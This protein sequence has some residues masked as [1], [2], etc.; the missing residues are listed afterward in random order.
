MEGSQEKICPKCGTP[1]LGEDNF[2]IGC[3]TYVD[4]D[5]GEEKAKQDGYYGTAGH[6]EGAGYQEAGDGV[7]NFDGSGQQ[8][9]MGNGYVLGPS[10]KP[11]MSKSILAFVLIGF[12]VFVGI[13]AVD[14]M[15][16]V[17]DQVTILYLHEAEART[18]GKLIITSAGDRIKKMEDLE[19]VDVSG[20]DAAVVD[21]AMEQIK[22]SYATYD[23]YDFITY[24]VKKEN[25]KVKVALIYQDLDKSKNQRAMVSMG[26][27]EG[28]SYVSLK[29]MVKSLKKAGWTDSVY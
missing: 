27:L 3:G 12:L 7:G 11:P 14:L 25:G 2:C 23:K 10:G 18:E 9:T 8:G 21:S 20:L 17:R 15:T 13:F 16:K 29:E 5:G 1:L 4:P 19:E 24:D 22:K 28:G 6:Y 26:L